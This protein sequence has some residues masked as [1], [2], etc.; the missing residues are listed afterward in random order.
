[1][2][3]WATA[4]WAVWLPATWMAWPPT[5]IP[6]TGYSILYEYGIF[7]QKIVDGWQQETR[8]QLAARRP[9][10]AEKPPRPG[11]WR[12]ALTARSIE[13]WEGGFHHVKHKNYNSVMAVPND[14]YVA[15]LRHARA[16]PSCACG[17]PRHPALI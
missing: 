2:Q 12:S 8:R 16:F 13:T 1:M 15:G 14:M 9:G 3:A 7:K 17:R 5:G 11:T 6:G 10:V 4:A